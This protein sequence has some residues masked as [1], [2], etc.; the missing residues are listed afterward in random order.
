MSEAMQT[1]ILDLL[2]D[3]PADARQVYEHDSMHSQNI[4]FGRM[5]KE[6]ANTIEA[7]QERVKVLELDKARLDWL[8]SDPRLAELTTNGAT[9]DCYYYAVAGAPGLK[10]R[11][12]MDATMAR[13][14]LK[15][16]L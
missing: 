11:E 3:V 10:L 15:A 14:V 12:I 5:A 7:L 9:V 2:R 13:A 8:E 16:A 4:P 6:A 1:P